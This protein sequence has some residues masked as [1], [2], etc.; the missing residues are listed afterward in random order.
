MS[1]EEKYDF[2]KNVLNGMTTAPDG[3]IAT[4]LIPDIVELAKNPTALECLHIIDKM[5]YGSLASSFVLITFQRV[6][7]T[8][9]LELEGV[10][11]ESVVDMA[12]WRK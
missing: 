4:L 7:L 3:Q 6:L 8:G 9:L 10:S 12:Y 11:Y 2:I 1:N 5:V